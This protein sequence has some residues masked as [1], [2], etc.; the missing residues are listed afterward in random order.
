[1]G[2]KSG[3]VKA[4]VTWSPL[5]LLFGLCDIWG[6]VEAK[7]WYQLVGEKILTPQLLTMEDLF[8]FLSS[9]LVCL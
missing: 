3:L 1:M 2:S 8:G 7:L 5:S 4:V 6:L 9:H